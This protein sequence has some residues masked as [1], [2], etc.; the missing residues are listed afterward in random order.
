MAD[1]LRAGFLS[2]FAGFGGQ[3]GVGDAAIVV[4]V[5]VAHVQAEV[6]QVVEGSHLNIVNHQLKIS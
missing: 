4:K 6:G 1:R 5:A 2:L 3:Q